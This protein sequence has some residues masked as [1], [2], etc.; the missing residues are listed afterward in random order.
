M[1]QTYCSA[2]DVKYEELEAI[3]HMHKKGNWLNKLCYLH[4]MW[5]CADTKKYKL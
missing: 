4:T 2:Y 3:L 1:L 5:S